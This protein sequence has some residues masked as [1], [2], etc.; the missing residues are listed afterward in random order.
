[1][2]RQLLLDGKDT[3]P[4]VTKGCLVI[5]ADKGYKAIYILSG[6][7]SLVLCDAITKAII[8]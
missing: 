3:M 5:S 1:M 7:S 6:P 2:P 4:M 8:L